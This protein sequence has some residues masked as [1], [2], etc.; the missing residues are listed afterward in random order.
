MTT[1]PMPDAADLIHAGRPYPV[2]DIRTKS[3]SSSARSLLSARRSWWL[4]VAASYADQGVDSLVD[5]QAA[6]EAAMF[7]GAGR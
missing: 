7:Y 4:D 2:R 6:Y 1:V 3:S 5:A